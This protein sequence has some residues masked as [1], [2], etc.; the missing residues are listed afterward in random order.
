VLTV[1]HVHSLDPYTF[2]QD[3][4]VPASQMFKLHAAQ[5]SPHCELEEF[6]S[7]SHMDAY[8]VEPEQYWGALGR[9]LKH[10]IDKSP[11]GP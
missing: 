9:F 3:E 2:T 6:Q 1:H 7:A 10:Y 5:T 8:D 4:M 11:D